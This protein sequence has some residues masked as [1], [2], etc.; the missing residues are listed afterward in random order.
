M[1][2]LSNVKVGQ[3]VVSFYSHAG[4]QAVIYTVLRETPKRL[5]VTRQGVEYQVSKANGKVV[6]ADFYVRPIGTEEHKLIA[7]IQERNRVQRMRRE[8]VAALEK[9]GLTD[10]QVKKMYAILE[11]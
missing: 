2:D 7:G 8:L 5:V 1:Y 10:D 9:D 4:L 6:G 11:Q 3:Q